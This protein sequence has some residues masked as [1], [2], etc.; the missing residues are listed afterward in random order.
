LR[1]C[2]SMIHQAVRDGNL[3]QYLANF[4]AAVQKAQET[5]F[6]RGEGSRGWRTERIPGVIVGFTRRRVQIRAWH[7]VKERIMRVNP[8]NVLCN[9]ED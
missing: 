9:D 1:K 6:L 3:E 5:P 2:E 7:R 8:D 4:A